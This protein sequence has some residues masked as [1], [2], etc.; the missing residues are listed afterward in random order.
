MTGP[1]FHH[2]LT[3]HIDPEVPQSC[4]LLT[5]YRRMIRVE[6]LAISGKLCR[7]VSIDPGVDGLYIIHYCPDAFS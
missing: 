7:A 4:I 1:F 5:P 2:C 6:P 3:F